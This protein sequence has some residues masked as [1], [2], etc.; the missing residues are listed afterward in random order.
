[1]SPPR[2]PRTGREFVQAVL[3]SVGEPVVEFASLMRGFAGTLAS[4]LYA[5]ARGRI[6]WREVWAQ[7]YEIGNRS[8]VFITFTLGFLGMILIFQAGFQAQRIT[9]DLQLLGGLF[10]QLLLREFAPTITALMI[11]TRVGTG[12]AAEIGSMVV[13]EQV[14]AMRMNAAPPVEYLIVP[15]FIACVVMMLCLVIYAVLVCYLAG[16]MT[17]MTSFNLNPR[18][19]LNFGFVTYADVIVCLVKALAY[20]IAIPIVA[21]YTGLTTHGGSAGVGWA[22][23]RS[24]VNCSLSVVLLDFFLSGLSYPFLSAA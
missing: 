16:M 10:L 1:M 5:I 6:R 22:T 12:I 2:D 17:A 9:G 8:I 20:G 11:A 23:T 13:T 21:G 4:V 7:A 3:G 14:D 18:T 19:F 24:V 15:R